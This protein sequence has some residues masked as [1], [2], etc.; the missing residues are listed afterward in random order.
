MLYFFI[1][2]ALLLVFNYFFL[3]AAIQ[4]HIKK[5]H[6]HPLPP[7]PFLFFIQLFIVL[8]LGFLGLYG[9]V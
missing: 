9:T 7:K 1:S 6:I 3:T 4:A 5:Y 2:Y 8:L